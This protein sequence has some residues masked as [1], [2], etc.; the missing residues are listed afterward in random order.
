MSTFVDGQ[1][2]GSAGV[3]KIQ[4][5]T[6]WYHFPMDTTLHHLHGVFNR[7]GGQYYD[8]CASGGVLLLLMSVLYVGAEFMMLVG[9]CEGCTIVVA[10]YIVLSFL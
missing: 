9:F 7:F 8:G 3:L 10:L 5:D 2:L 4:I 6:N 1:E